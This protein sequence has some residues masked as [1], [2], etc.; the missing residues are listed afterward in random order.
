M[1]ND[2]DTN[3]TSRQTSEKTS[4]LVYYSKVRIDDYDASYLSLIILARE[5]NLGIQFDNRA[6]NSKGIHLPNYLKV[7]VER[8]RLE[9]IIKIGTKLSPTTLFQVLT[10]MYFHEIDRL[11]LLIDNPI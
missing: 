4:N 7:M 2:A 10:N 1:D 3:E 11:K 5:Y 9:L 6:R 8:D